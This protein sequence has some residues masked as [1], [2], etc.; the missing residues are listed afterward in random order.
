VELRIAPA[1][2]AARLLAVAGI[3]GGLLALQAAE[4]LAHTRTQETTNV[5]SRILDDPGL[6]G[7]A[8][9]VHTGGLVIEVE[10]HGAGVLV[11]EGYEGEPFLRIGPDGV[12]RNRNSPATYLGEDRFGEVAIPPNADAEA[13]PEWRR[14]SERPRHVWHDHRVHW[15]SPS[16]P[17][18]VDA[19]PLE[20]AL[21]A[22]DLV[23][24]LGSA[25]PQQGGLQPWTIRMTYDGEPAVLTGELAWRDAPSPLPWLLV[26]GLLAAPGLL[27]VRRTSLPGLVRPAALLVGAV[28]AINAVHLVDDLAAWPS[29]PL[30]D[31][32]GLLHTAMFLTVGLVGAAWA[33]R[34]ESGR[35]LALGI[36]GAGVLYHQGLVRGPMLLASGF[37]TVWPDPLIRLTV[38]LALAQAVVVAV[39][40]V[41]GRR[42]E[43]PGVADQPSS[44]TSS[45]A[46][47]PAS[48]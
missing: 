24:H 8:W 11:V 26:A 35:L 2:T 21:M 17:R 30:D 14:L 31:L 27:G 32:F 38:A 41:A 42:R 33:W 19:G 29:H 25:G 36:A 20:R 12:E 10:N 13:A 5:V 45:V 1:T 15:M 40:L 37:P 46:S 44:T 23:G 7:V 18:V 39:V 43:G 28:A 34:A 48:R 16:P 22:L 6:P 9:T 4:A 47:M 3:V